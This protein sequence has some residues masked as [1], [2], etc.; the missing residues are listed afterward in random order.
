MNL[1]RLDRK[2]GAYTDGKIYVKA[3]FIRMYAKEKL[4]INQSRGALSKK[5]ISAY[6]LDVHGVNADVQ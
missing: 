4:G 3:S 1:I 2:S 5:V 6:F